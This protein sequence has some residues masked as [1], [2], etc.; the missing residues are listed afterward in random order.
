MV[1]FVLQVYHRDV[2]ANGF[3]DD[4]DG[5][6]DAVFLDLPSPHQVVPYALKALKS[7]GINGNTILI[8]IE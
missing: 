2:C 4:L 6:A 8:L 5:R 1:E 3:A 7:S